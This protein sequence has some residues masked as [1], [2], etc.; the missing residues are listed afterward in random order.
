MRSQNYF[1]GLVIMVAMANCT[2]QTR[3]GDQK[4][5]QS[6]RPNFVFIF[7][8]DLGY[9]DLGCFGAGDIQTPNIDG[10]AKGGIRFSEFYSASP[11]CSP[12]RAG[13][14]TGR[15]PQRM[16]INSVFFP[17]S[18]TGLPVDEITVAEVLR[19]AGYYCG[20]IGKWHLGH[21]RE[22]LPLQRGFDEYFGIPYSNDMESVVYMRGNE[23]EAFEVDQRY[24]TQTYTEEALKFIDNH[25]ERP[26]YL[27]VAH[28]MPH[29][30]I[31]ASEDFLGTSQR[32]LYGDV[33]QELD[34]SVGEIVK[35]L[36]QH[37]ILEQTLIVFSSDN[38]PWLVMEDHGGSAGILREGKQY[39]FEGGMRVPTVAMWKA[40]IPAGQVYE[41]MALQVD[42]FPTFARLAGAQ[43]PA[44]RPLDGEDISSVLTGE[45]KR[46][47][48]TYLFLDGADLQCY[49]RGD[50]KVKLPYPGFEG[51]TW[52]KAVPAHDTLLVNLKDDPGERTNL[53]LERPEMAV[54]MLDEM[55]KQYDA[56]GDLP[57]SLIIRTEADLSHYDHLREIGKIK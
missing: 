13:L 3:P 31:Y 51:A 2:S 40:K 22:F 26:F 44:D 37:G 43:L 21:R 9:G 54:G 42:W 29:V 48:D 6:A 10:M 49:R 7:A 24:I 8:D 25:H 38:G 57:P 4:G 18:F 20:I 14:L 47:G 41:D 11:V 33:I 19:T 52:K 12:S 1:L 53:Y 39:T 50:W 17:E 27:Y 15:L 46:S 34:W 28:N 55:W 32:G 30:P 36:E 5:R 56:M 35:K 23:V 16:G 45:G